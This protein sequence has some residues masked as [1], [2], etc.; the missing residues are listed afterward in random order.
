MEIDYRARWQADQS[1][2]QYQG[3]PFRNER[4][5]Y[6]NVLK[7]CFTPHLNHTYSSNKQFA[8]EKTHPFLVPETKQFKDDD[9]C[10]PS[11]ECWGINRYWQVKR[12]LVKEEG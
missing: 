7:G 12:H 1:G 3:L 8:D 5:V 6:S 2:T 10:S 4:L 11:P 9:V